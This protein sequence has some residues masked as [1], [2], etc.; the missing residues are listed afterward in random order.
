[1]A[2]NGTRQKMPNWKSGFYHIAREANIPIVC[3]YLDFQKKE[4]NIGYSFMPTGNIE[5]DMEK[6]REYYKEVQGKYPEQVTP[7]RLVEEG[8]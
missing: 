2:P 5:Q 4:A 8:G 1:M 6:V 3:G 7:V